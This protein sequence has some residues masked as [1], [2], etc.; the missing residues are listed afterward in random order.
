MF[1]FG[2][3]RRDGHRRG[4]VRREEERR[5]SWLLV[6]Q[7]LEVG[8]LGDLRVKRKVVE[9]PIESCNKI[10]TGHMGV[11]VN[12]GVKGEGLQ[13]EYIDYVLG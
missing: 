3:G 7:L 1:I 6:L 8:P 9:Q 11:T 2:E 4:E 5:G 10:K 12:T 13:L